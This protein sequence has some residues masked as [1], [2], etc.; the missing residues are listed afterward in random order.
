VL[1]NNP[2]IDD[3]IWCEYPWLSRAEYKPW[4]YFIWIMRYLR[5]QKFDIIF[6]MRKAT[7]E[8]VIARLI[9][10]KDIIGFDVPKS[11]WTNTC[12]YPYDCNKHIA[13]LFV[14]L[15]G[16]TIPPP[17]NGLEL[18]LTDEEINEFKKYTSKYIVLAHQSPDTQ[19]M[20][21]IEKWIPIESWIVTDTK[22]NITALYSG[23]FS[24]RQVFSLIKN[25]ELVISVDSAPVHIAS[26]VRTPVIAL[27]GKHNPKH[28]GP[29]PNGE[30]NQ[31]ICKVEE[32]ECLSGTSTK[33]DGMKL[34]EVE[35][36]KEAIRRLYEIDKI[37][38]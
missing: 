37:S 18:F 2:N 11:A 31:I 17:H 34:I 23:M 14:D 25:A 26:A 3:I 16:N 21:D 5:K 38:A 7:K 36:V 9:G 10:A 33:T 32:F 6:N 12:T 22:Y 20:W 19:K 13:D 4:K 29:Y 24:L 30:F 8:A 28:W 27:Y 15:I 35:D 1:E